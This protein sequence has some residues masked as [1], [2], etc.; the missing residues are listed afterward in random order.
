MSDAK[1][2]LTNEATERS[3]YLATPKRVLRRGG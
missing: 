2:A 3:V 1:Q